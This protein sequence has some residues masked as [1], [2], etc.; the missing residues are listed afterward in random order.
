MP[1]KRSNSK[2]EKQKTTTE[3]LRAT[4]SSSVDFFP[5]R[6]GLNPTVFINRRTTMVDQVSDDP[7]TSDGLTIQELFKN[8]DG[9]TY[10]DFIILPGYIDFSSDIVSLSSRLT[11]KLTIKTPFI[12]SPMDTVTESQMASKNFSRKDC[13]LLKNFSQF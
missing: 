8:N 3:T 5:C 12:S 2:N 10:N 9:L 13:F 11:K 1:N 7:S 6:F 4:F